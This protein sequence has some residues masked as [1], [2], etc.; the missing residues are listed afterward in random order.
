ML[1]NKYQTQY[2]HHSEPAP[3]ANFSINCF[4]PFG[5]QLYTDSGHLIL[6]SSQAF[7]FSVLLQCL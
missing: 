3:A 2:F 5:D 7:L 4:F 6:N 1:A